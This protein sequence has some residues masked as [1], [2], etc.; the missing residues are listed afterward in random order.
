[1]VCQN[2]YHLYDAKSRFKSGTLKLKS[3]SPR[4]RSSEDTDQGVVLPPIPTTGMTSE[5][6]PDLVEKTRSIML[7]ALNEISTTTFTPLIGSHEE[8]TAQGMDETTPLRGAVV[9]A[10][11]SDER[12]KNKGGSG[13]K[14]GKKLAIA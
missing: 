11:G 10:S 5:D 3:E 13:G 7:D 6:I 4:S 2:Y 1:M 8:D 14:K 12:G 9:G